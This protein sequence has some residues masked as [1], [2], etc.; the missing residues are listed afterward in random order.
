MNKPVLVTGGAG[1]IGSHLVEYLIQSG[2]PVRVLDALVY[3]RREWVHP[4]AEFVQGDICDLDTC[5]A[6]ARGVSGVFHMAAMSRSAPSL[7]NIDVCT[8]SNIVGTQNVLIAAREAR[9]D[10]VVYSGSS[11]YYGSQP[12]PH[13]EYETPPEFLNL[14]GLSKRVGEQ[15]CL[16]FDEKF[17]V[18]TI[19]LR[20]FNV[21]GPRQP[22]TG[23]YALV[24]GIFLARWAAGEPLEIHG[25][26]CQRR[27]FV[28][29]RDVV[30]ANVMAFESARRHEIFNVGS[31]TNTSIKEL[32]DMISADQVYG[33]RRGADALVTLAD[34]SRIREAL[35][36]Q[37][38]VS[39]ETGV[40]ELMAQ[41]KQ[42]V[43]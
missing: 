5:R 26:G 9:V 31:G 24:L 27:D 11:T 10:K 43:D 32:A 15:Y 42:E 3:G 16:L 19:V 36:W 28:H 40:R 8:Q 17:N 18:P 13:R 4:D 29:V 6:A 34:I 37:P 14:Y 2:Y 25:D 35:G 7:D 20:Y 21:Y 12:P 38:Q 30:R 33:P 39:F 22:K 41:T 1:F 23:A